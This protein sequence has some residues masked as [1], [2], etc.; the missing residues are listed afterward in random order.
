LSWQMS[1]SLSDCQGLVYYTQ[2]KGSM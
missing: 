2:K 1:V